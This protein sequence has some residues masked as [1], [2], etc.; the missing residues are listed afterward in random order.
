MERFDDNFSF[1]IIFPPLYFQHPHEESGSSPTAPWRKAS[2]APV[3]R[4]R[5]GGA[6][7]EQRRRRPAAAPAHHDPGRRLR[8]RRAPGGAHGPR[9]GVARPQ[10]GPHERRQEVS[11]LFM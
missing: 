4:Q 1:L 3:Q 8:L 9:R 5:A 6:S 11:S 2:A 7:D 10:G